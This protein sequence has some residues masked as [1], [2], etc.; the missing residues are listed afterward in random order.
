M[1]ELRFAEPEHDA[2]NIAA[3]VY[4]SVCYPE[5]SLTYQCP[6]SS[7]T[8]NKASKSRLYK[9]GGSTSYD[10]ANTYAKECHEQDAEAA[11]NEVYDEEVTCRR[12]AQ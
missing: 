9:L 7:P 2:S 10:G 4:G 11:G 8:P 6:M 12:I 1:Y 3:T 5:I